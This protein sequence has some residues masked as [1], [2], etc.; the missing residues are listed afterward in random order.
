M[1]R[2]G[3]ALRREVTMVGNNDVSVALIEPMTGLKEST[4]PLMVSVHACM[5]HGG[6]DCSATAHSWKMLSDVLLHS[7]PRAA[8]QSTGLPH[9]LSYQAQRHSSP[10]HAAHTREYLASCLRPNL[11]AALGE[12]G[13]WHPY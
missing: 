13:Q 7:C 1:F 12:C 4:L 5:C 10:C 6:Q 2:R 8:M 3:R 11:Q 9:S